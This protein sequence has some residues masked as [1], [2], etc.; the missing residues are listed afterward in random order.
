[1]FV[2]YAMQRFLLM[3]ITRKKIGSFVPNDGD[4]DVINQVTSETTRIQMLTKITFVEAMMLW[5][6]ISS[7]MAVLGFSYP[8][9]SK[10]QIYFVVILLGLW[11]TNL[12]IYSG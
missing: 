6:G 1:M 12:Q 5:N 3:M 2:V 7:L 9:G 11:R 4:L 10:G 8:L